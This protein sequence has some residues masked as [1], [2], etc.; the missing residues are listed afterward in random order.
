MT[1]CCDIIGL[2]CLEPR[3]V[4]DMLLRFRRC[5]G[6]CRIRSGARQ[7]VVGS[8]G[9]VLFQHRP[10]RLRCPSGRIGFVLLSGFADIAEVG[11]LAGWKR[12]TIERV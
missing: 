3:R 7:F 2:S 5:A 6:P 1:D 12:N 4:P 9:S 8:R 10:F 11:L